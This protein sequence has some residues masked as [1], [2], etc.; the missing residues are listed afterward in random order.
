MVNAVELRKGMA[1]M[2][3]K[4]LYIVMD[5]MHV[6]PGNWRGYVQATLR[7]IRTGKSMEKR[8]R[9]TE[10]VE[11]VSLEPKKMT[12]M[13][14]DNDGHHF[15]D[16]DYNSVVFSED[17]VGDAKNYLVEDSTV[18]VLYFGEKAIEIELPIIVEL[19]IIET[20]PGYRGDSVTNIQKPATLET[21]FKITVPLFIKEGE[22]VKVD[23][24]TGEYTGRA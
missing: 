18:E 23:T 20:I 8:F 9:S 13:Y 4:E 21:G 2:L 6:T 11:R 14:S 16:P 1:I 7:N 12:F 17:I 5:R 24:R 22:I 15:M 10:D 19:K 3:E